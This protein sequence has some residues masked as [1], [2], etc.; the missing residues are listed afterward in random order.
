VHIPPVRW[1]ANTSFPT[2]LA[3]LDVEDGF[4]RGINNAG[5]VVGHVISQNVADKPVI[6]AAGG[7]ALTRL[8]TFTSSSFESISA[9]AIN[10]RGDVVGVSQNAAARWPAGG[11]APIALG[12]LGLGPTQK[13]TVNVRAIN[14][15]GDSVGSVL[16]Y[17]SASGL[18][19]AILWRASSTSALAL[20][21]LTGGTFVNKETIANAIDD[22]GVMAGMAMMYSGFQ[23]VDTRAVRWSPGGTSVTDLGSG[24]AYGINNRDDIVG[25]SS[26][27]AVLWPGDGTSMLDLNNL[28]A[29]DSGWLLTSAT[30]ISNTGI[31]IGDGTYDP[32]GAGPIS[33]TTGEFRLTPIPEPFA[34]TLMG[35]A[36]IF[37]RRTKEKGS[38]QRKRV[39]SGSEANAAR[40]LK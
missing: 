28:I 21:R 11:S 13:T 29:P 32:D 4:G 33:P 19:T 35:I 16:D 37:V 22:A 25:T 6:W 1:E 38:E 9:M 23:R 36:V 24:A 3:Y 7:T 40:H 5:V 20:P 31:I 2:E 10:D 12:V 27:R 15:A 17:K 14:S 30:D 8:P 39:R 34:L 18:E 26:N